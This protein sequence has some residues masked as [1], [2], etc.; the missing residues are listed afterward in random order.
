MRFVSGRFLSIVLVAGLSLRGSV[1]YGNPLQDTGE[2]AKAAAIELNREGSASVSAKQFEQAK[3][4]FH[5]AIQLDPKLSDAYENLALIL[6]LEGDDVAAEHTA[7]DLLALAPTNYNARFVA[8]VAAINRNQFSKGR[9]YLAPLAREGADDPLL[10]AAYATVLE[11]TGQ[12]AEAARFR[13]RCAGVHVRASDALLAGQIFRQERVKKIAQMWL[14]GSV[15]DARTEPNPDLL[16]SLAAMYAEQ[17]RTTEASRL[18]ERVL[19]IS[20][21]NVYALVELSELERTLGQQ[22][23]AVS[24]LYAAKTLAVTDAATLLHFSQACMRRHMYVDA[25]DAL[26]KVVAQDPYNR[27]AWYQLGLA[28][29]RI[30]ETEGAEKDFQAALRVDRHDEWSRVGLGAVLMSAGRQ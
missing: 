14:E 26:E 17:R 16:Y 6:L 20:P 29:F 12:E 9:N 3:V 25:K 10:T 23:Q 4:L 27:H 18:Y 22:E 5:R 13:V 30:G 7:M 24:H 11:S 2:D 28:Q 19:E 21:N 15:E 1:S 8:G